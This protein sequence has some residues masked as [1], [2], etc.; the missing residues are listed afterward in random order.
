MTDKLIEQDIPK[1]HLMSHVLDR[2]PYMGNPRL[3]ANWLD[4]S[5][6]KLL[7]AACR[8]VAQCTFEP[9]LLMRMAVLLQPRGHKRK[10][11]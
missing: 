7:K 8:S 6:N 9:F 11:A 2:I 3:Y 4:E 5:L 10:A 1:R